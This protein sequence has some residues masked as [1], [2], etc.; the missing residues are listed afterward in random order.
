M[1][2]EDKNKETTNSGELPVT[3]HGDA[4]SINNEMSVLRW[5]ITNLGRLGCIMFLAVAV[6]ITIE[7]IMR[8]IFGSPTLWATEITSLLCI[9]A[10]FLLFPTL[11]RKK[12]IRG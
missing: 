4:I 5:V 1:A 12:D 9:I 3:E 6:I 10:S 2:I 7:V 11:C 8:F